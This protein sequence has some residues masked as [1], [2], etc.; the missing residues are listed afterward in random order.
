MTNLISKLFNITIEK[1]VRLY[2]IKSLLKFSYKNDG[3][4]IYLEQPL[5]KKFLELQN[6][7]YI[8][9]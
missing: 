1:F 5:V 2:N 3:Y 6:Y 9:S 7:L 8:K 4:L